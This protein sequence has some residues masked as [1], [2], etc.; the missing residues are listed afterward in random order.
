MEED[1]EDKELLKI[2][3]N[4]LKTMI[5]KL[6]DK[7]HSP[8][9]ASGS[10]CD[11]RRKTETIV[12]H[13]ENVAPSKS[14]CV[15]RYKFEKPLLKSINIEITKKSEYMP[16]QSHS[17][18]STDSL[19]SRYKWDKSSKI[20]QKINTMR[21]VDVNV[22]KHKNRKM[23]SKF[24][25]VNSVSDH[26]K[27]PT[28]TSTQLELKSTLVKQNQNKTA[29][30]VVRLK[31]KLVNESC[32]HEETKLFN[33]KSCFAWHKTDSPTK[34][35]VFPYPKT[36]INSQHDNS[37]IRRR[38][39]VTRTKLVQSRYKTAGHLPLNKFH[40]ISSYQMSKRRKSFAARRLKYVMSL[41]AV[42]H[43]S[44]SQ[45]DQN[46]SSK[47]I[48][49]S[50]HGTNYKVAGNF[51]SLR[52]LSDSVEKPLSK[53]QIKPIIK[54]TKFKLQRSNSLNAKKYNVT[55]RQ[56]A[57]KV[58]RKSLT[59]AQRKKVNKTKYCLF[60][61]RF[62]K[63]KRGKKCRYIHDPEKIAVCTRFLRGTCKG[64]D[65]VFSHKIDPK[66]MPVCSYFLLGKCAKDDCPYRHVNV[67]ES[68]SVCGDFLNGY[69]PKEEQ[70]TKKHVLECVEYSQ[71]G[72]CDNGKACKMI[73]RVKLPSGKRHHN[74][75][76]GAKKPK[77]YKPKRRKIRMDS[78]TA[79]IESEP[80]LASPLQA[81]GKLHLIPKFI[82]DKISAQSNDS[83]PSVIR[84][85]F[86]STPSSEIQ[87]T[88]EYCGDD[89]GTE[90]K[91]EESF[92][93][94]AMSSDSES[95]GEYKGR[96]SRTFSFK[97]QDFI[98]L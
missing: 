89:V 79:V 18:Q 56:I 76:S 47:S 78:Q 17:M 6:K 9:K 11:F 31:Y 83:Q 29:K 94:L 74:T 2:R 57:S 27:V 51:R 77:G 35:A 86:T 95:E 65:C 82:S 55:K 24:K 59:Q 91:A 49:L 58:I 7:N 1:E 45:H 97:E 72:H 26:R 62:G 37:F 16:P 40:Q 52:R 68:A 48:I 10:S 42:P 34:D 87:Y 93:S 46:S 32:Q 19:Q 81:K 8:K 69:C 15:S 96:I 12:G 33:K 75:S 63:C 20:P 70:C 61:N 14:A 84:N 39:N 53:K 21:Q 25:V 3:M 23:V 5:R 67:G 36:F 38:Y 50:R 73:H 85:L 30:P 13:C 44:S 28:R 80:L 22:S 98:A 92:I 43:K 88:D 66:K 71:K 41:S 54:Q 64:G 4:T 90:S 60:Y